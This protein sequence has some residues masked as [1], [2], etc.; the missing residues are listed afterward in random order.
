MAARFETADLIVSRAGATTIAE[1]IVA[2]RAA[3]LVPFAAAA[4][5]HQAKNA[6]ELAR[7]GAAEVILEKDL[8]PALLAGRIM[9]YLENRERLAE[10]ANELAS[11]RTERPADRIADLCFTL[12]GAGN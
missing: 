5:D 7:I 9:F 2:R 8:S 1:L 6:G 3:I 10:M 4:D 11:L 12:M